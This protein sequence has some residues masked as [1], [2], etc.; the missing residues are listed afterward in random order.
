MIYSVRNT[1]YGGDTL[2]VPG[3]LLKIPASATDLFFPG[4]PPLRRTSLSSYPVLSYPILTCKQ[5]TNSLIH[6]P[7]P[8]PNAPPPRPSSTELSVSASSI[9][10]FPCRR[11]RSIIAAPP[12]TATTTPSSSPASEYSSCYP[13]LLPLQPLLL[14]VLPSAAAE[15]PFRIQ[16]RSVH[17]APRCRYR[18]IHPAGQI[19]HC[20]PRRQ[21]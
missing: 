19:S 16:G 20:E 4:P 12:P 1:W 17:R 18:R 6:P 15:P 8:I 21:V 13:Y 10:V 7:L 5:Y 14:D 9:F 2:T 11:R 3:E